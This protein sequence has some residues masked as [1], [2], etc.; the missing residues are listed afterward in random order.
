MAN[1][2][3]YRM[4]RGILQFFY[5]NYLLAL[6]SPFHAYFISRSLPCFLCCSEFPL[7]IIL[8]GVGD[9]P[10]D[11][12]KKY[13]DNIPERSFDN[14]QANTILYISSPFIQSH[15]I[16]C[17]FTFDWVNLCCFPVCKFHRD[18][19]TE[20]APIQERVRFCP[21]SFDGNTITIY[22]NTKSWHLRVLIQTLYSI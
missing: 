16:L 19:V 22:G 11:M 6:T 10:W 21:G 5:S 13:D 8:V 4:R 15:V 12:M 18:N 7:S 14:F 3:N 17:V 2:D 9:G 20:C 1:I